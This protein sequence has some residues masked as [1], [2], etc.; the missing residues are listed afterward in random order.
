MFFIFDSF[1]SHSYKKTSFYLFIIIFIY[2]FIL[3][4]RGQNYICIIIHFS[5]Y[6][7]SFLK[8]FSFINKCNEE[9]LH[10]KKQKV[11]CFI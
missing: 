5:I 10:S 4:E 8:K 9:L 11:K 7:S 3:S 2:L 1:H 6:I